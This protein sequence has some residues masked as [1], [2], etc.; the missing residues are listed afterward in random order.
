MD[1]ATFLSSLEKAGFEE[2]R[3]Y[4]DGDS[5]MPGIGVMAC[6]GS[7]EFR[8][9]VRYFENESSAWANLRHR[10]AC[11]LSEYQSGVA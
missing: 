3:V 1:Q 6:F 5:K 7:K 2:I 11:F 8:A 10:F 4:R 9:M